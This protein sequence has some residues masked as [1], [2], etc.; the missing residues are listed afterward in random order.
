[1]KKILTVLLCGIAT[2]AFSQNKNYSYFGNK[3]VIVRSYDGLMADSSLYA[4]YRAQTTFVPVR[5][6]ALNVNTGDGRLYYYNGTTWVILSNGGGSSLT[7]AA[8]GL[9]TSGTTVIT[10]GSFNQNT[11]VAGAGFEL[12]YEGLSKFRLGT[13]DQTGMPVPYNFL[14]V[15]NS[16][17]TTDATV[18]GIF[19][20][21]QTAGNASGSVQ[22]V[23]GYAKVNSA[24]A[25]NTAIGTVGNVEVANTGL[26]TW[27]RGVQGG[28]IITGNGG[29]GRLAS[30]YANPPTF[31]GTTTAVIDSAFGIYVDL[32]NSSAGTGTMSNRYN[33][34]TADAGAKNYFKGATYIVDGTQNNNYVFTTDGS[35]HGT[36]QDPNTLISAPALTQ[37]QVAFGDGSNR[38]TSTSDF[39]YNSGVL[40]LVGN[41]LV[42]QETDLFEFFRVTTGASKNGFMGDAAGEF[43][44]TYYAWDDDAGTL[45]MKGIN[46]INI[47][48]TLLIDSYGSGTHTGTAAYTLQV[49][50]SGNVIEG[51]NYYS[52]TASDARYFRI[53]NNLSEGTAA[54]MRTN[55]G[56]TTI[57]QSMFTLTN[58]SAITFPRFNADNTVSA[59]DAASFRTAIGAGTGVGSVTSVAQSFTGGL[60][61]V[62]GSP[63]TSSG[64]LAL[65][66]AGT[67]GG[68]PYFSSTSTW[69]SSGVLSANAI[70]I[71]GGAG[72]AP[73]TTTTGTGVLV[74]LGVNTGTAGAF[75]VNGGALGTP[76]SGTLTNATGLPLTSGVTGILPSANGGTGVNNGSST[77]TLGGNLVTSGSFASTFTM[78][79]T[80]TVTFPTTGTLLTTTG[81]GTGLSGVALLATANTFTTNGA[82]SASA[83]IYSGSVF[84]GGTATTTT[85]YILIQPTGTSAATIWST[86]GTVLGVNAVSG[87]GGNLMHL[88]VNNSAKFTVSSVGTITAAGNGTFSAA[89]SAGTTI[90]VTQNNFGT[91]STDGVILNNTQSATAGI[92][93]QYSTR[94]HLI[95]AGWNTSS[96]A[97]HT[98]DH[99][100]ELVPT[101]ANPVTGT[102]RWRFQVNAGGYSDAATLTRGG[103]FTATGFIKGTTAQGTTSL[104]NG[105]SGSAGIDFSTTRGSM[106]GSD[107]AFVMMDVNK[108]NSYSTLQFGSGSSGY[109]GFAQNNATAAL[110]MYNATGNIYIGSSPADNGFKLEVSGTAKISGVTTHSANIVFGTVG[111][112]IEYQSGTGA[113]AGNATL[114]GGTVT[115]TNT[116][117]TANSIIMLTRK[118]SGGTIGTAITYTISAGASFT[119][120][121]DNILDTSTFSYVIMQVN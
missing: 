20:I 44:N 91:T 43:N 84:T 39:T 116:N 13:G 104:F 41:I 112:T 51:Q 3:G 107:Y 93:V 53:A 65:T 120:T 32:F 4:T 31:V 72:T 92:P 96:L 15:Y 108:S 56:G 40:N 82:V 62:S 23:E 67:S 106:R 16:T 17:A 99:I 1:M 78:T 68:I 33:I 54:T 103:D 55:I 117:V 64:T 52:Q 77:I 37:Q 26:L 113:M 88:L 18:N 29:A 5:A 76:A 69:A 105:I 38:M 121:S 86:S 111:K 110:R 46:G 94:I 60:I 74:A 28:A 83:Q 95:G 118:T 30:I 90:S 48:G 80:T 42:K 73:S 2:L 63:I 70:V 25:V 102:V 49:D 21:N 89:L 79:G 7:G 59:L 114:V 100:Y 35:G 11:T 57:G 97:S 22:G 50:A 27:G 61:S 98:V 10:G 119:I 9:T 8:N 75:V 115:V 6:G 58:P 101:S 66:V 109:V 85:P 87:F 45:N 81:S 71:G 47:T 34:F 12:A 24:S 14:S 19:R 36:W